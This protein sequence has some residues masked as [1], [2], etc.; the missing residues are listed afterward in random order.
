[1]AKTFIT[2]FNK[3]LYDDYAHQF[4]E[5]YIST[6]QTVPIVC[7]VEEDDV[8]SYPQHPNITYVN[9]FTAMPQCPEFVQRHSDKIWIDDS[10]FL[11]NAVRFCYKVFA[12]CHAGRMNSKVYFLD[13]DNVF[14]KQFPESV[15]EEFLSN[16]IFVS[17]YGRQ[18][19][20][21]TGFLAFN[22]TQRTVAEEFFSRYIQYYTRDQIYTLDHKTDCH[23]FDATRKQMQGIPGYTEKSHGDGTI[24]HVIARDR[25][26]SPY[27]DHKKGKRKYSA[28][29]PEWTGNQ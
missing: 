26:I 6:S 21:E 19:F 17:F 22:C 8:S 16:N 11:Q 10:N 25:N 1:M 27:I 9:L 24:G 4:L 13:A 2:T 3:R 14:C 28:H 23:A 18:N 29:S 7:Y 15:L 5:S 12:Q 20:T